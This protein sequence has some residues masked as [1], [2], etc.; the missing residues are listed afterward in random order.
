[1]KEVRVRVP[2]KVNLAL[3]VGATDTEGYHALGTLFQ[4]V[5]L[6]DDLAA[7]PAEAGVFRVSFRGEGAS[8]LP[9]D[10][11][12]LVVRAA[13]LLAET[14][15]TGNL[16]AEIRVHKRIP[17]AGGMAGGSAD[18]AATLVACDRLWGTGLDA[19]QLHAL[20]AR[21]GADVPF[22]LH[23][24]TAVGTGR[25]E[26]LRPVP[27]RGRFHWVLALSHHGLSTPAVFREF[28]RISEP[29]PTD[30][31]PGLL[32][33]LADGDTS[34]VGSLLGNDLQQAAINLQPELADVLAMGCE[35]GAVGA[36]VSGSGP[37][38]AFL[39]GAPAAAD[40]ISDRLV[41]SSRV[42]AVRRVHGPVSGARVVS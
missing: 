18:A 10:D 8:G 11:T 2:A 35:A 1:M 9:V 34:G 29:R 15:G 38:I 14:C 21:L 23:G 41:L 31:N 3:N 17:V 7:R 32:A 20:A 39:A 12:N 37:T 30:I 26:K 33:A 6:F 25:G 28:D 22:L 5:S 13:R 42:R 40:A 27:V 24:G 16:G 4:A 19:E 36:L